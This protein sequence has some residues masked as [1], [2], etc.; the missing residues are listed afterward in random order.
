MARHQPD[1][2]APRPPNP[3]RDPES[4]Y[5]SRTGFQAASSPPLS[6]ASMGTRMAWSFIAS[7]FW[8]VGGF[9]A[10]DPGRST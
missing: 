10:G 2:S 9:M 1:T 3:P 8:R 7:I 5:G 6:F 4:Y